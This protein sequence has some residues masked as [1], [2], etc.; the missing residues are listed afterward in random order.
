MARTPGSHAYNIS[1][2]VEGHSRIICAKLFLQLGQKFLTRRFLKF[3]LQWQLEFC[4]EL[5]SLNNWLQPNTFI[6]GSVPDVCHRGSTVGF[7]LL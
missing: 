4:M 1:M 7:L 6:G 2:F 5:K 3:F